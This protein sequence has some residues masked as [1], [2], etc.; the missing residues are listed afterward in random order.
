MK[1]IIL[2]LMMGLIMGCVGLET[3]QEISPSN[4]FSDS[5]SGTVLKIDDGFEYKGNVSNTDGA[6]KRVREYHLWEKGTSF[7]IVIP[8]REISDSLMIK[9]LTTGKQHPLSIQRPSL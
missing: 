1:K 5:R 2:I 4:I 6:L 9:I 3:K 8:I 7:K